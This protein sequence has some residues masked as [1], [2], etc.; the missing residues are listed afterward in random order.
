MYMPTVWAIWF[1]E[2][3]CPFVF[4]G[5]VS[6]ENHSIYSLLLLAGGRSSRMG[7]NKAELLYDDKTFLAH[8]LD[9]A[10]SLGI[11]KCFISGYRSQ[12]GDVQAVPDQF[13]DRGPLGGIHAGLKAIDTP[14]CLVL[15][16]DAP[17]L[18]LPSTARLPSLPSTPTPPRAA[19]G[20]SRLT[21]LCP[22]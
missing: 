20:A 11:E 5:G 3:D 14:Y 18:P 1:V 6:M 9:K 15:P 13:P 21:S 19:C 12:R 4:C 7:A 22:V 17:L 16:I 10:R 8:M 2:P